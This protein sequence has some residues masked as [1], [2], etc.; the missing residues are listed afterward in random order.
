MKTT[1]T[2][3]FSYALLVLVGGWFGHVKA[4]S[5]ASLISGIIFG[6]ALSLCSLGIAKGKALAHYSALILVFF[7]DAF[8]TLRFIKTQHFMPAGLMS[9]LS[10]LMLL[11]LALKVRKNFSRSRL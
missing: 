4:G 7:L 10:F 6:L 1:A 9:L 2:V 3:V 8:F 5:T 11:F